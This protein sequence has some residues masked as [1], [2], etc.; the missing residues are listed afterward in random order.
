[1]S[2]AVN[3]PAGRPRVRRGNAEDAERLRLDLLHAALALFDEGGLDAV[4]VRA[5]AARV[6]VSPMAMYR[7]FADKRAL[8]AGL[9]EFSMAEAI[10][11]IRTALASHGDGLSRYRIAVEAYIGF[12]ARNPQKYCLTY[13]FTSLRDLPGENS[14]AE[15]YPGYQ[16]LL[17]LWRG[18]IRELADALGAPG[19]RHKL[20]EDMGLAMML[21]Y[22][23]GVFV[24]RRYPWSDHDTLRA[25]YVA[26][27]DQVVQRCLLGDDGIAGGTG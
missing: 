10:A 9:A 8:L 20:A 11:E 23:H 7:Y 5:V 18:L 27:I 14:S 22:M 1:M 4:S 21:G 6:G 24:V 2:E 12:W 26:E 3:P 25:A 15:R 13:G 16:Q 19:T 17:D